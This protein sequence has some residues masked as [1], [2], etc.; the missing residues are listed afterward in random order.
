MYADSDNINY[1]EVLNGVEN[2]FWRTHWIQHTS[3][4][5]VFYD[6]RGVGLLMRFKSFLTELT[7]T[8][9]NAERPLGHPELTHFLV[10]PPTG[11]KEKSNF[12][13]QKTS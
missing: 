12:Q 6:G 1:A 9:V 5:T 13:T 2:C 4:Q 10:S 3:V 8:L 7:Y 11:E